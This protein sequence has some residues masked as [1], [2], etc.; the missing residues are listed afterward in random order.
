MI[1][2]PFAGQIRL[3]AM[4]ETL[5]LEMMLEG[6]LDIARGKAP[7]LVELHLATY[8]K[9]RRQELDAQE[10]AG[11]KPAAETAT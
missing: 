8:S 3:Q 1:C 5:V 6:V 7:Y 11:A 10:T 2:I 9:L 4:R